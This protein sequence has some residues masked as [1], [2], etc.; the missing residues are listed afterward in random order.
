MTTFQ[1]RVFDRPQWELLQKRLITL[2]DHL[3]D[4][5]KNVHNI[6]PSGEN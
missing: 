5:N 6:V 1:R 2:L 4:S 3:K